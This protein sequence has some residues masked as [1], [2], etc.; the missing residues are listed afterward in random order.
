MLII[1]LKREDKMSEFLE[2]VLNRVKDDSIED[3]LHLAH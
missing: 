3:V 1:D 2:Y